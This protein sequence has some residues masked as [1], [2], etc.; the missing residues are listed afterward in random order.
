VEKKFQESL[1]GR[2]AVTKARMDVLRIEN[3]I[4]EQITEWYIARA[5]LQHAEGTILNC[6]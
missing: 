3:T 6:R 1:I 4:V 5:R 2:G